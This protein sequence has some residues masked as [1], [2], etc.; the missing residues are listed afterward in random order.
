[1]QTFQ[2]FL[3][4][5]LLR[6]KQRLQL[7]CCAEAGGDLGETV[8]RYLGQQEKKENQKISM[9]VDVRSGSPTATHHVGTV[10]GG[11]VRHDG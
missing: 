5:T 6:R 9:S 3:N 7:T 8:T 10:A 2:L 1:M 11:L 4:E